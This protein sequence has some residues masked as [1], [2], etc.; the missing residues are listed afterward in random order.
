MQT[1]KTT[2]AVIHVAPKT[3]DY[4]LEAALDEAIGLA[5][6]IDLNIVYSQIIQL[7]K[8]TPATM[9]GRGNVDLLADVI[10]QDEV[11]LVI[12]DGTLTPV[13]QRNLEKAWHC[14]VI[15][16]TSL[17][18][19]IFG[20]R[21]RTAEGRLQVELAALTYQRSR[22]VRSWTHLERQ[23][24]GFGFTGGPGETQLELDR[25]MIDDRIIR[26][27][28]DLDKTKLTRG[29]HR[30]ARADVP[31]PTV[32]LVGY[33]NAGKSTLF[34]KLTQ[35]DVLA[36]DMLFATLD[37]TM[38][39]VKLPSGRTIILSDTV[40][41]IS[42]LPTQLVAAFRATL[43]EV[44]AADVILHVQDIAHPNSAMQEDEVNKVL[45]E[46]G[47]EK[48]LVDGTTLRVMNKIDLIDDADLKPLRKRLKKCDVMISAVTADGFDKLLTLIDKQLNRHNKL[49]DLDIPYDD[50][51]SLAWLYRQ[52]VII[53][54][55]DGENAIHLKLQISPAVLDRFR[56]RKSI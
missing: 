21:A 9:I 44:C 18:L 5:L 43:E 23:R 11:D 34:N 26:I 48:Q 8:A 2:A 1:P 37:P 36:K 38:R 41:F 32:A 51:E 46:L 22:L 16:R 12:F 55:V 7:R 45:T 35:A 56:A 39:Q 50:G 33:T 30:S 17:I 3:V 19:E 20:E 10:Q 15:D 53:G 6:A 14:K 52:G 13:Q 54:R 42:H 28:A 47:L 24:G 29:L 27:K 25:R 4:D 31:Y 49:V 40:G